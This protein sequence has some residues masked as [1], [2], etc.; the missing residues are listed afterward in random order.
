MD[1][2][3]PLLRDANPTSHLREGHRLA[4]FSQPVAIADD[5]LLAVTEV[6]QDP[7]DLLLPL[8]LNCFFGR[9]LAPLVLCRLEH[10]LGPRQEPGVVTVHRW[11]VCAKV[12]MIA[13]VAYV[14]N[15]KPRA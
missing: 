12:L 15:L 11:I 6:W 3:D 9:L 4:A 14:L 5:L 13:W 2:P 8:G 10:V 7:G 1:L